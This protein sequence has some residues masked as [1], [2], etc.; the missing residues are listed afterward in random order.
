MNERG[1]KI[2]LTNFAV[3]T[4]LVLLAF[5]CDF[6]DKDSAAVKNPDSLF[7]GI[8]FG[9]ERKAFY[10]YCWEQN[11]KKIFTHGPAN[12]NVEYKI[13]NELPDPVM[14]RF[15]PSFYED[16]IF[17]MPVVFTYAAWAP[18]NRQYSADTLLVKMMPVF[19]KWYGKGFKVVNHKTMG[20]VYVKMD[21]K[22]R[23]NIFKRDDQF[24]QAVFTDMKIKT[25]IQDK[26][27]ESD[28][29]EANVN[30]E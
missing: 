28:G 5:S 6:K 2:S 3:A 27:K 14:M 1:L 30:A 7:L 18:W 11:R 17:E 19:E 22:R 12:Q 15:Y 16:K 25:L 8:S 26:E 9:M 20:K 10:E 29:D 13:E 4:A 21:G 24:I 23:I